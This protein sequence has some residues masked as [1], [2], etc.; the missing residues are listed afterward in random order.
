MIV[1]KDSM[2]GC[3]NLIDWDFL[4]I[5]FHFPLGAMPLFWQGIH[6]SFICRWQCALILGGKKSIKLVITNL[7]DW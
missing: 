6:S 7:I 5:I 2:V 4:K 3:K 1:S